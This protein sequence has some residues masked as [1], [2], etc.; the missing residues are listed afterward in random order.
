LL[1]AT[2]RQEIGGRAGEGMLRAS[3]RADRGL[4][5]SRERGAAGKQERRQETVGRP[6]AA[7]PQWTVGL[8]SCLPAAPLSWLIRCTKQVVQCILLA[9]QEVGRR[10][11]L[12]WSSSAALGLSTGS[13]QRKKN[14]GEQG[15]QEG[16]V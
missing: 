1:L 10:S 14:K 7:G 6:Q 15:Q 16:Y 5:E 12:T 3:R 2:G 4:G 9:W 11:E 8:L 13:L